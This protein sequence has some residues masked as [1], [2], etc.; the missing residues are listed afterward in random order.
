MPELPKQ[1][2]YQRLNFTDVEQMNLTLLA[3]ADCLVEQGL[4]V[5]EY[6]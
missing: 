1:D 6:T 4:E 3:L 2:V 5:P